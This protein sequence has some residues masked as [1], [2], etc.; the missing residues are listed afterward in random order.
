MKQPYEIH[1]I[2]NTHW[3]RE[4]LCNFQETRMMLMHFFDTLLD[5]LD[6]EP[7]YKSF[8]LDSQTIPIEDYLEVRPEKRDTIIKHVKAGR[9]HI[10]PWYTAPEGFC[11]AGESIVRNLLV[12]HKVARAYGGVMKVGHTPFG[13]GQNSQLPQIYAG[14]GIDTILFYHG[15][16][17]DTPNE[18]IFEGADGTRALGSQMSS[19]ARYNFYYQVYRPV[20]LGEMPMDRMY[21]WDQGG[22]PFHLADEA[23]SANH[24]ILLDPPLGFDKGRIAESVER[25]KE[26]E[27]KV[28]TTPYFAFMSGHDSSVADRVELKLIEAAKKVLKDATICHSNLPDYIAKV[29]KAAKNL[30]VQK[31]EQRVPK[32]M[33]GRVHLYSDVLSSRTRMKRL[34]AQ[35]EYLLQ[36]WAEPFATLAWTAGADYPKS[37]LEL[38]WKTLLSSH[39]HDSIAGS[40]VDDIEQDMMYRLRQV[41]NIAKGVRKTALQ[42]IQLRVDTSKADKD[43]VLIT[44]FNASAFARSEVVTA[45]LDLPRG[46]NLRE[47]AFVDTATRKPV[48]VQG[49]SRRP[50]MTVVNH[51]YDA[52]MMMDSDR[53][54]VHFDVKDV[55]ALGYKT[56]RLEKTAEFA[57]G[58]N[59]VV[60]TNTMENEHLRVRIESD[61]TFTMT[62]KKTGEIFRDL[63]YFEDGGEAGPAWMHVEPSVDQIVLSTGC[64]VTISLEENG[65]LLAR[66]RVVYRMRVPS[67]IEENGGDAWKRLDGNMNHARRGSEWRDLDITSIVTLRKGAKALEIKTSFTNTA[68]NHRLRVVFPTGRTKAKT[69]HVES[70]FDVVERDIECGPKHPW[71]GCDYATFPMQRF[72]DVS[73]GKAG[74][75]VINHGLREY[76]VMQRPDRA[77]AVT[78]MRAFEVSLT[79]VSYRWEV[80]PEMQ[81]SQ[82]PGDHEFEYL[83]YPHAG[84][85]EAAEVQREAEKLSVPMEPAQTAA[86]K[87]KGLDPSHS[88]LSVEP[89][90][91]MLSAIKQSEDGKGVVVRVFNPTDK[92]VK[93]LLAAGKKIKAAQVLDLE[94]NVAGQ[95]V[96]GPKGA[97]LD[98]GR[99]K[100]LT[101]KLSF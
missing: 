53:F 4:W 2:S 84:D 83:V 68:K 3:D 90:A 19:A 39:A 35:A 60:A 79:T 86:Y 61:G 100:I 5:I 14:F 93:G 51:A 7:E 99:K 96:V 26:M 76:Q 25:L 27:R 58:D 9:L 28:A 8:L 95:A 80:H 75:A 22:L 24:H 64:P 62:H 66:Y 78:L 67:G 71:H 16:T 38:A 32:L 29:K 91:L 59:L 47:F 11:V 21:T 94:E 34:N 85:W 43:D 48:A 77:I 74:M 45:V 73:D 41:V 92:P 23:E 20:V 52:P 49:Y 81:L 63:H 88:F 69:C 65:P 18:F 17:K 54:V 70:A 15:I 10:G 50:L 36:R 97:V 46:F 82:C 6:T 44:V 42:Q 72:V 30:T 40:G 98:V 56:L 87:G 89:A 37:L 1:V 101:L 33:N 57:K 12:G 55:P 13:Y 31:G